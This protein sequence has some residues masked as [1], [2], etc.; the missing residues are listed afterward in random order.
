MSGNL[1]KLEKPISKTFG[2]FMKKTQEIAEEDNAKD[3]G[4]IS[5][6]VRMMRSYS[7]YGAFKIKDL[8]KKKV[9]MNFLIDGKELISVYS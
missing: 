1:K 2:I 5:V 8:Q 9:L 7:S 3:L 6:P 4:A